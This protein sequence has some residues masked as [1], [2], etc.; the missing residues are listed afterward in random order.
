MLREYDMSFY[1][2]FWYLKTAILG[3]WKSLKSPW[4]LTFQFAMNPASSVW[5]MPQSWHW[6]GHSGGYWQQMEPSCTGMVPNSDDDYDAEYELKPHNTQKAQHLLSF[7]VKMW[8]LQVAKIKHR[9]TIQQLDQRAAR[10]LHCLIAAAICL[11]SSSVWTWIGQCFN[12]S[13]FA[14]CVSGILSPVWYF[15]QSSQQDLSLM[16]LEAISQVI[17]KLRVC[18][19]NSSTVLHS[20]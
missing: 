12:S 14:T 6:T 7:N 2:Y 11:W 1:R 18:A 8:N 4:I 19:H 3:P 17:W 5:K 16:S 20:P 13:I 15:R 9:P 10:Y